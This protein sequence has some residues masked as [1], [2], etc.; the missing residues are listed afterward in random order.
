MK[1]VAKPSLPSEVA[2]ETTTGAAIQAQV[3]FSNADKETQPK[4]DFELSKGQIIALTTLLTHQSQFA[5]IK[6]NRD[7]PPMANKKIVSI[8]AAQ[9][10]IAPLQPMNA[11]RQ[12]EMQRNIVTKNCPFYLKGNLIKNINPGTTAMV[13]SRTIP[14]KKNRDEKN[15]DVLLP[16]SV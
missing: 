15:K 1:Q 10:I 13:K 8:R 12:A 6:A 11:L 7:D 9:G 4:E 5:R 2:H 14:I 3:E 16:R